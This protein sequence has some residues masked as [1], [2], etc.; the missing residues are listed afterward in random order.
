MVDGSAAPY[1]ILCGLAVMG[2]LNFKE[3]KKNNFL[4]S[5]LRKT[6]IFEGSSL[7]STT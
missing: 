6:V 1:P 3:L 5:W 2:L 4:R 7:Y